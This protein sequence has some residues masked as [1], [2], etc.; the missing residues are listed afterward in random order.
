[1]EDDRVSGT[2]TVM[3]CGKERSLRSSRPRPES[4][5]ETP[6]GW[7][8]R[9]RPG[10]TRTTRRSAKVWVIGCWAATAMYSITARSRAA[11][12][13]GQLRVTSFPR[14]TA[15]DQPLDEVFVH[16][17][18]PRR[19]ADDL[20]HDGAV[21]VDDEALRHARGLVDRA[22]GSRAVLQNVEG[23]PHLPGVIAHHLR[24]VGVDAHRENPERGIRAEVLL[25][26][27]DRR[28]LDAAGLAPGGPDVEEQHPAP[29]V[30]QLR[31]PVGGEIHR[32]EFRRPRAHPHQHDL[33]AELDR[34]RDGEHDRHHDRNHRGPLPP[35]AHTVTAQRRRSSRTS[36][37]GSAA[38]KTAWPATKVSAPAARAAAMVSRVI[39]PS[40]SRKTLGWRARSAFARRILPSD[41]GR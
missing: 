18:V 14:S 30:A 33:G 23:E 27:L 35:R 8:S 41:D 16:G 1:M 25:Q 2:A 40:T 5:T 26:A 37:A 17:T 32:L 13:I 28:H 29:V 4:T 21:P 9:V 7:C 36:A 19:G 12:L 10:G 20:L 31:G 39:P 34:E 24:A 3:T 22:D 38:L 15:I 11:S 6:G